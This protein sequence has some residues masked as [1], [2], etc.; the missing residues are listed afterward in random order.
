MKKLSYIDFTS[1]LNSTFKVSFEGLGKEEIKKQ[2]PEFIKTFISRRIAN[3]F[4]E[5]ND[6]KIVLF[7][8]GEIITKYTLSQFK[9]VN[10]SFNELKVY[11][12]WL[13]IIGS[14]ENV[15]KELEDVS[16]KFYNSLYRIYGDNIDVNDVKFAGYDL[17]E[18]YLLLSIYFYNLVN[19]EN[20]LKHKGIE[21][22]KS[23]NSVVREYFNH[24]VLVK[25]QILNVGSGNDVNDLIGD[26]RTSESY[27]KFIN[28]RSNINVYR[29]F[30]SALSSI[31]SLVKTYNGFDDVKEDYDLQIST[32]KF[33]SQEYEKLKKDLE[34][35]EVIT[36][37]V[38]SNGMI[39]LDEEPLDEL[40]II[41]D[42][43]LS[44]EKAHKNMSDDEFNKLKEE[45]KL[46]I[47]NENDY[48]VKLDEEKSKVKDIIKN[49]TDML[50]K[51]NNEVNDLKAKIKDLNIKEEQF[52][53]LN[54]EYLSKLELIKV[55]TEEHASRDKDYSGHLKEIEDKI[56]EI[57]TKENELATKEK[58]YS[59]NNKSIETRL[60]EIENLNSNYSNKMNEL[61]NKQK[62]ILEREKEL[63]ILIEEI[64]LREEKLSVK[65]ESLVAKK[66]ELITIDKELDAQKIEQEN[67]LITKRQE[68]HVK[69][70]ELQ[71][72]EKQIEYQKV[73][74]E[75]KLSQRMEELQIKKQELLNLEIM[76]EK[77][78][79]EQEE[80]LSVKKEE[81]E[82]KRDELLKL[83]QEEID[84][85]SQIIE[86]KDNSEHEEGSSIDREE[87][88]NEN[89]VIAIDEID[90]SVKEELEDTSV[91]LV[92][93]S[94]VI[95]LDNALFVSNEGISI[96]NPIKEEA[97]EEVQDPEE[98]T[99]E[100]I[101]EQ[102]N[103]IDSIMN[104]LE[105]LKLEL[106]NDNFIE[107]TNSNIQDSKDNN[108]KMIVSELESNDNALNSQEDVIY[109]ESVENNITNLVIDDIIN[110]ET[111]IDA[112]INTIDKKTNEE[113]FNQFDL[114]GDENSMEEIFDIDNY[115]VKLDNEEEQQE[116][117]EQEIEGFSL[118]E[119]TISLEE[120]SLP[121]MEDISL[122]DD[123]IVSTEINKEPEE[124]ILEEML[125]KAKE[126]EKEFGVFTENIV[127]SFVDSVV[128]EF[129]TSI[130]LEEMEKT[131]EIAELS[132]EEINYMNLF[133]KGGLVD[134]T[135]DI[136]YTY[137]V[138]DGDVIVNAFQEEYNAI[139]MPQNITRDKVSFIRRNESNQGLSDN[140]TIRITDFDLQILVKDHFVKKEVNKVLFSDGSKIT[141]REFSD[142]I[143]IE[144]PFKI[145]DDID[146]EELLEEVLIEESYPL[147]GEDTG[148]QLEEQI[149]ELVETV[150]ILEEIQEDIVQLATLEEKDTAIVDEILLEQQIDNIED[151]SFELISEEES[152][153]D[154]LLV[155]QIEV[156]EEFIQ[157]VVEDLTQQLEVEQE[158]IEDV[159][160]DE[161]IQ[162]EEEI[163]EEITNE[164]VILSDNDDKAASE[165]TEASDIDKIA[166][167]EEIL[168]DE[169]KQKEIK[170][171]IKAV[172]EKVLAEETSTTKTTEEEQDAVVKPTQDINKQNKANSLFDIEDS[173]K[174]PINITDELELARQMIKL[175]PVKE[176]TVNI[177]EDLLGDIEKER[178]LRS[179]KK[180]NNATTNDTSFNTGNELDN[181][182]IFV[183]KQGMGISLVGMSNK[184]NNIKIIDF[185][186]VNPREVIANRSISTRGNKT[187]NVELTF[188]T[189]LNDRIM[190]VD[191]YKEDN[192]YRDI[193]L[194]FNDGTIIKNGQIATMCKL[195][196]KDNEGNQPVGKYN[197]GKTSQSS[198]KI[199]EFI[200]PKGHGLVELTEEDLYK[201]VILPQGVKA[202][203]VT[204]RKVGQ[205]GQVKKYDIELSFKN[206]NDK[207]II[208]KYLDDS[209]RLISGIIFENGDEWK[210]DDIRKKMEKK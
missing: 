10:I 8:N 129:N 126:K 171:K 29:D 78:Q 16:K 202:A 38:R 196:E 21:L 99:L 201:K 96:V 24:L 43:I 139:K 127:D 85:E 40:N 144:E 149:E 28:Y 46:I 83:E 200:M 155:E 47:D 175:K 108:Q 115:V 93:D 172:V 39:L 174:K 137:D 95:S 107:E 117:Q 138:E 72:L 143:K 111:Q 164:E 31:L 173:S 189:N 186:G 73:E 154:E 4:E 56:N 81:V 122:Q 18:Y 179:K 84:L 87:A 133:S 63:T 114:R 125:A 146:T 9:D 141:E 116:E 11:S 135:V 131:N 69:K 34:G 27:L 44:F 57:S 150:E 1:A 66:E 100:I 182:N 5:L 205:K 68:L 60:Q 203:D 167:Q 91:N 181:K 208:R 62:A 32:L 52:E 195:N 54:E 207:L 148:I 120:P 190:I 92:D 15:I 102:I 101:E 168:K 26:I 147:D 64:R 41:H 79:N 110:A 90:N 55:K 25:D 33:I 209:Q 104:E 119:E 48:K 118:L 134:R 166:K 97:V 105:E 86:Y 178:V 22:V 194:R 98:D 7:L 76:I 210:V 184:E 130:I 35:Q 80:K 136:L 197:Y 157:P 70:V 77:Q 188:A 156:E 151:N 128:D 20:E 152:I 199:R 159:K 204:C 42:T 140:L 206:S 103:N 183:Y 109:N 51:I 123:A 158:S 169:Q 17:Y 176:I 162:I 170:E 75:D 14:G 145:I 82:A 30:N 177:D 180:T 74:Q 161:V 6:S 192:E 59:K 53:L 94:E 12:S 112:E 191:F 113:T 121:M 50:S 142:L 49:S 37:N 165:V 45:R 19:L 2:M 71:D 89:V 65:K 67:K 163:T 193:I 160:L 187:N 198:S 88:I 61:S 58:E 13:D 3:S 23:N 106:S 153:D 124:I 36:F 132:V 185:V